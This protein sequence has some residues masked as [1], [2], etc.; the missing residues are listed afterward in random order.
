MKA[1]WTKRNGRRVDDILLI[2][3]MYIHFIITYIYINFQISL[4]YIL[5][6]AWNYSQRWYIHFTLIDISRFVV[7]HTIIWIRHFKHTNGNCSFTVF[8]SW[9]YSNIKSSN[10]ESYELVVSYIMVGNLLSW[11][12]RHISLNADSGFLWKLFYLDIDVTMS[13]WYLVIF[14]LRPKDRHLPLGCI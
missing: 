8:I 13:A 9:H 3:Y 14:S 2:L 5:S 10:S 4:E 1:I 11:N 7:E 6:D 12:F